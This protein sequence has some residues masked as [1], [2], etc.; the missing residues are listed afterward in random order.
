MTYEQVLRIS[1]GDT[2]FWNDPDEG[3]C[4]RELCVSSIRVGADQGEDTEVD[5]SCA[6]GSVLMCLARELQESKDG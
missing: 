1:L 6:D 3:I 4:S 5:L 2:V